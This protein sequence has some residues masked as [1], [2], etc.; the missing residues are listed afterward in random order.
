MKS[1][2]LQECFCKMCFYEGNPLRDSFV[3]LMKKEYCAMIDERVF[4]QQ[5]QL[6]LSPVEFSLKGNGFSFCTSLTKPE[7]GKEKVMQRSCNLR[8][9]A[10]FF[11]DIWSSFSFAFEF[12]RGNKLNYEMSLLCHFFFGVASPEKL[13][14]DLG[15]EVWAEQASKMSSD[16]GR[17]HPSER[18]W[19]SLKHYTA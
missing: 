5:L 9:R 18:G 4:R 17:I 2:W 19:T 15:T 14:R 6:I 10:S 3:V 13:L 1:F 16:E 12:W 7:T 8:K 11:K